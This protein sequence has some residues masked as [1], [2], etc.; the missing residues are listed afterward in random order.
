MESGET[1]RVDAPVSE[2]V[3]ETARKERMNSNN[4]GHKIDEDEEMK[5]MVESQC[6]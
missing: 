3:P 1:C 2:R 4:R 6:R 5:S